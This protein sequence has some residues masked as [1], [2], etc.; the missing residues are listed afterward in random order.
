[1]TRYPSR[2]PLIVLTAA[3]ASFMMSPRTSLADGRID[4]NTLITIPHGVFNGVLYNRY[5]AMFEGESSSHRP[6]RVPCQVI[7]PAW[8]DDG[9]GFV[10][11]DWL[12]RTTVFTA[13]GRDFPVARLMLTD[14][15]LFAEGGSYATVR[16]DPIAIGTPWSDGRLDTS[17][18]FIMSAGDEYD[19]VADFVRALDTDPLADDLLGELTRKGAFGYSA[20]GW[21][22]R[23][24]LRHIQGKGLFDFSLIGGCGRGYDFPV[25][26]KIQHSTTEKLPRADAGLE[27]DF[28]TEA[29]VIHPRFSAADS[30]HDDMNYRSY[31][32]AGCSHLR[33]VDAALG[34]LPNADTANPADWFPF[35]RA[36]LVA[37]YA[38][39]DGVE[40]PP[41][42][43]LGA[44]GDSRIAR[45]AN[46]NALVRFVGGRPIDTEGYRLP[47]V[48]VGENRYIAY[49]PSYDDG[50]LIG[51][52][53]AIF[54][55]FV[56]LTNA[57]TSHDDYVEQITDH[58][59]RLVG[60]GYLLEADAEEII[61][62]AKESD[63]GK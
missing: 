31:E 21:R 17:A 61:R 27:I 36:L 1:M 35:V 15:F 40:P 14:D 10:L 26:D 38:W 29:E 57:F 13:L 43:W 59:T 24:M 12:N 8:P 34:G 55:G 6:Y 41:S 53:R 30:R 7:A 32:F 37:G 47:E 28:C 3:V 18:E 2:H 46:G 9:N 44:P 52:L 56:D 51:L 22:L 45:D 11:F 39:C 16:C 49:D 5:E 42:I 23:G 60:Q 58:T 25:G 50:T 62:R 20:S 33:N 4:P 63:I 48:A 54:G 19:I